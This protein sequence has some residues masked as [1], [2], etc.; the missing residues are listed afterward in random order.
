MFLDV[1]TIDII[2]DIVM[3]GMLLGV[4][5]LLHNPSAEQSKHSHISLLF[6]CSEVGVGAQSGETLILSSLTDVSI[7]D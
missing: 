7:S 6:N 1:G 3:G 5:L 2:S 4:I